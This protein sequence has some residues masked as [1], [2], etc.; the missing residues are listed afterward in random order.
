MRINE[1]K[2]F[3][4]EKNLPGISRSARIFARSTPGKR[5]CRSPSGECGP[6]SATLRFP[7]QSDEKV[8]RSAPDFG[9]YAERGPMEEW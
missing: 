7:M 2:D 9:R 8:K 3:A 4:T 5:A 1:N 6:D